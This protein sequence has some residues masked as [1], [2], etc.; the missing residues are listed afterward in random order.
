MVQPTEHAGVIGWVLNALAHQPF[1]LLFLVVGA[2]YAVG[3]IQI[4]KVGLG[5]TASTLIIGLAVSLLANARYGVHISIPEFA[6]NLFFNLFMFSVGVKV[7]PQF[8]AGLKRDAK[9]FVFLGIAVPLVSLGL[10]L[11]VARFVKLPPGMLPGVFAGANTATPGFGAAHSAILSGAGSLPAG[12]SK[13]QAIANLSTSFALTY[14]LSM[15]LFIVMMKFLPKIFGRDTVEDAKVFEKT[16]LGGA[17]LPGSATAFVHGA[18]PV[19][20]RAYRIEKN[21]GV[22][23]TIGELK[24]AYPFVAIERVARGSHIY[25]AP[26]DDLALALGD[27]IVLTGQTERI[28]KA[29]RYVG[30]EIDAPQLRDTHTETAEIV[31]HDRDVIGKKLGDLASGVGYGLYL[32]AMFRG[33]D[34]LPHGVETV[35]RKGDVLRVV[36]GKRHIDALRER[37]G[38]IVQPSLQT[39]IVTVALGLSIG[40]IL[41]A[42]VI[43][44]GAIRFSL[45]SAVGLLLV[46][47]AF[48]TIRTRNPAFGGPF[49]EPARALLEDLGLNV[50]IAVLGLNAGT[51]VLS[52]LHTGALGPALVLALV[53]G[54]VPPLLAWIDGQYSLKMNSALLM[55]A[56]SGARCNSGGLRASQEAT[57]SSVPA[58]SYPVTFA[59]SNI[60]LT[61]ISYMLVLFG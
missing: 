9:K 58:I 18:L 25:E 19:E 6:S 22:G 8:I 46:G 47:I 23:H 14:S 54:F 37:T 45:G 31:V 43:P 49:P 41:G 28:L 52:A 29:G 59:L 5:A 21:D 13:T 32:E 61:L 35:V 17:A 38:A 2:G 27:E 39:D 20:I 40:A 53:A 24:K 36:G 15:V 7:G 12:V 1:I 11:L 3:A 30:P 48:G 50:F 60:I 51:G 57:H 4:K 34:E 26:P 44:I 55:G 56:V 42:I 16:L 33:G 10:T